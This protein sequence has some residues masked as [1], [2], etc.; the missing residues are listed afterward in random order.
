MEDSS[1]KYPDLTPYVR[2]LRECIEFV[3][4][5]QEDIFDQTSI[6]WGRSFF[7]LSKIGQALLA[8]LLARNTTWL[9]SDKLVGCMPREELAPDAALDIALQDLTSLGFVEEL[10]E[11]RSSF[12]DAWDATRHCLVVDEIKVLYNNVLKNKPR[13]YRNSPGILS[14]TNFCIALW[15]WTQTGSATGCYLSH[16]G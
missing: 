8:R 4:A 9:R 12:S 6:T 3:L 15:K 10:C 16:N 7:A 1:E 14:P 13:R 11:K 2:C 5:N